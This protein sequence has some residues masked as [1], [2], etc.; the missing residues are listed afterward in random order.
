MPSAL[1]TAHAPLH[2]LEV[3]DQTELGVLVFDGTGQA[4]WANR[5]LEAL[6]G[7][8]HAAFVGNDRA[9]IY[10]TLL[11]PSLRLAP[12]AWRHLLAGTPGRRTLLE[13]I[14][15]DGQSRWLEHWT[16]PATE[17]LFGAGSIDHL[18]DVTAQ[19]HAFAAAR[20]ATSSMV[21][22]ALRSVLATGK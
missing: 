12:G 16:W 4:V 20:E 18:A 2:V 21:N 22:L 3:L 15:A 6:T 5:A 7:Q 17:G 10:R 19:Q 1:P 13:H 8:P 11:G 14:A 9:A